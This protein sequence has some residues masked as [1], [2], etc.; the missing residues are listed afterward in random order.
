MQKEIFLVPLINERVFNSSYFNGSLEYVSPYYYI[1]S[2]VP[3]KNGAII[4]FSDGHL[5]YI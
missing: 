1:A 5:T 3:I 4:L 2:M